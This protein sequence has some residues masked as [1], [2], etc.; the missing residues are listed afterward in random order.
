MKVLIAEDDA[1]S[2][3]LLA[4][5][6]KKLGHEVFCA[7]DGLDALL[8]FHRD[9]PSVVITDWMMPR[10]DGPQL[11]RK[12]RADRQPHYVYVIMVTALGGKEHYVEGMN[13]GADDFMTK[14]CDMDELAARLLAAQRI[15]GLQ[16]EVSGLEGLLPICAYCKRIRDDRDDWQNLE[17]YVG[18]K[19]RASFA[20]TLCPDCARA[21]R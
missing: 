8:S 20:S 1:A 11:C 9:D 6:L 17:A 7:N 13:A 3:L 21:D 18:K 14:P 4:T 15:I 5:W 16:R 19:T 12:I 10:L 2:Q